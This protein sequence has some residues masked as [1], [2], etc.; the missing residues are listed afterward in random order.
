MGCLPG[1]LRRAVAFRRVVAFL[2]AVAVFQLR[3]GRPGPAFGLSNFGT[4]VLPIDLLGR[5]VGTACFPG[6][7]RRRPGFSL[8]LK[9]SM[10]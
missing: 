5:P 2:A 3:A 4:T 9:L 6:R 10:Q 7:Y 1:R 8:R